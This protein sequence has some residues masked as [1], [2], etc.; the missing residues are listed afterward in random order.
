MLLTLLMIAD[1]DVPNTDIVCEKLTTKFNSYMSFHVSISTVSTDVSKI[2]KS[3]L[4]AD[5]WPEGV[6]VRK[7]FTK[8]T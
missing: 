4:C 6:L 2:Y 5:S 7:F 8:K 3:V 1:L